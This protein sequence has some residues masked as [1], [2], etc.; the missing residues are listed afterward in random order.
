MAPLA[1]D[2]PLSVGPVHQAFLPQMPSVV[3]YCMC[4]RLTAGNP[5]PSHP[6]S[7]AVPVQSPQRV[8]SCCTCYTHLSSRRH[9]RRL[10]L[11]CVRCLSHSIMHT[12]S[13]SGRPLRDSKRSSTS[14]LCMPLVVSPAQCSPSPATWRLLPAATEAEL[15]VHAP[16]QHLT[17]TIA[18]EQAPSYHLLLDDLLCLRHLKHAQSR[19]QSRSSG[20]S[21]SSCPLARP[22]WHFTKHL[23]CTRVF[24]PPY[25]NP[26]HKPLLC[27]PTPPHRVPFA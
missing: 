17:G 8:T 27:Y 23:G 18:P 21:L 10:P 4:S 13:E 16:V 19:P 6:A 7:V 24:K 1:S 20:R 11:S 2:R 15:R 26:L 5:K 9:R 12:P 25:L 14:P 22:Q 3:L